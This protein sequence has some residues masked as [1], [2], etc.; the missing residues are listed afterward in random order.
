MYYE[1]I[2]WQSNKEHVA[3]QYEAIYSWIAWNWI[4][5]VIKC[6]DVPSYLVTMKHAFPENFSLRK[7]LKSKYFN[8]ISNKIRIFLP[9]HSN[10]SWTF[11]FYFAEGLSSFQLQRWKFTPLIE[12]PLHL[13]STC[14]WAQ[15]VSFSQR[16]IWPAVLVGYAAHISQGSTYCFSYGCEQKLTQYWGNFLRLFSRTQARMVGSNAVKL[17]F[18]VQFLD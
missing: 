6:I 18:L 2:G 15:Q 12:S 10:L 4:V 3:I 1:T 16:W 17:D 8:V 11:F 7:I 9:E 13:W 14:S 5:N